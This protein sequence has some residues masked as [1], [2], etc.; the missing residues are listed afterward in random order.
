MISLPQS[1]ILGAIQGLTEFI[2]VSSSGHLI[3]AREILGLDSPGGLAFD[4]VLQ[5]G[6]A[7]AV[8]IYFFKDFVGL[9]K[10][11]FLIAVLA[12]TLPALFLG[13]L[14]EDVM[15]TVFRN[16]LLVALAL[17]AGSILF[18]AAERAAK[19]KTETIKT[20]QA[21]WIGCFQALALIP[22]VSRSGATISGGLLL[23]LKREYAARFSFLLSLPIIAGSGLKK[24]LNIVSEGGSTFEFAP[25]VAGFLMSF[26]VGLICIRWLL[27]YLKHH[28]LLPF[29]IYRLILAVLIIIFLR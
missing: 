12:G 26:F 21:W 13:I 10:K 5:L 3:L 16:S 8:L 9:I 6:T 14:L 19:Q 28:S 29:V 11:P 17:V 18:F 1:L 4:A 20:K 23:G 2:P 22:G 27:R 7:L 25:L 15:N 24:L